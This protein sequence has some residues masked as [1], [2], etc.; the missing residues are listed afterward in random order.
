MQD[1]TI[2][3]GWRPGVFWRPIVNTPP[4]FLPQ[5]TLSVGIQP[6]TVLE[7][8]TKKWN[9]IQNMIYMI[10]EMYW[11]PKDALQYNVQYT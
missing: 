11:P 5:Y 8:N 7:Q 9:S 1:D 4:C 10:H 6:V 2:I 3:K